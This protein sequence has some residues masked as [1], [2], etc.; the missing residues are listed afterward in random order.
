MMN[1]AFSTDDNYVLPTL[2][3]LASLFLKNK[4]ES[5]A[6]YVI[7]T[8]LSEQNTKRL[9]DCINKFS[10]TSVLEI[11]KI[12]ADELVNFPIRK[13]DHVSLATYFRILLP[14]LL[15]IE[16]T[17]ILYLDGDLLILDSIS[18]FYNTDISGFSCSAVHDERNDD[19]EIFERLE[20]NKEYGY[21]G[22]GVLLINL[23]YWRNNK[24]Q[25]RAFEFINKNPEK[26]LWHD[27]DALNK[28]LA[29][30]IFWTDFRY[31]FSQGYFFDKSLLKISSKYFESI[32]KDKKRPCI[33]HF[34]SSYKPWNY[35]CNHP[36]KH[37]YRDFFYKVFEEK[38]PL[39]FRL[40]GID[41]IKWLAKKILNLIF[42]IY[43]VD[44]RKT[45]IDTSF[46][47]KTLYQ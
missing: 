38:L 13:G 33:I 24:I 36:L 2:T 43:F 20:Y 23:E 32:E 6:V 41:R 39:T 27:Q 12:S 25:E 5:F 15:P 29:G 21:F 35:E 22:A 40:T 7:T 3:T 10:K 18:D 8:G 17:R 37:L 31:N 30:T 42:G 14:A 45:D 9:Q 47:E 11:I 46:L 34:T 1:I 16:V 4:N 44:F 26:C 19:F 28:I